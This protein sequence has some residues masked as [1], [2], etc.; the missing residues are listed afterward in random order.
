MR[1]FKKDERGITC[2]KLFWYFWSQSF[3][4]VRDSHPFK[5]IF[6]IIL[7]ILIYI[8]RPNSY[9]IFCEDIGNQ[10]IP[11][12]IKYSNQAP[13]LY[14]QP[15]IVPA[16]A[17]EDRNKPHGARAADFLRENAR[18]LNEPV[19]KVKTRNVDAENEKRWWEWSTPDEA[20]KNWK[21]TNKR[22]ISTSNLKEQTNGS[23][24]GVAHLFENNAG[25]DGYQTTYQKEHGFLTKQSSSAS[26]GVRS[27]S[28]SNNGGNR[29]AS[30][31]NSQHA[32][33]IV[34]VTDLTS[35]SKA[36]EQQRVFVDKVSFEQAYDSRN[37]NNYPMRGRV[38]NFI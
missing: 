38:N 28:S 17:I 2:K 7:L 21:I 12:E 36:N 37:E 10:S 18:T 24:N 9:R 31:P 32:I 6:I 35:Y 30:N 1:K 26:S 16:Q 33:G 22:S 23:G 14:T 4:T 19:N 34:P 29:H 15:M 3:V 5:N 8:H 13:N 20:N 25:G 27:E 11:D